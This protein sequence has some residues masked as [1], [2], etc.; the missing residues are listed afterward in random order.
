M[1]ALHTRTHYLLRLASPAALALPLILAG[2]GGGGGGDGAS[3]EQTPSSAGQPVIDLGSYGK[4]I[5]PVQVEGRWYYYW[6]RSG[7]GSTANSGTL[8]GGTDVTTHNTLDGIFTQDA[9]GNAN[10][11]SDTNN[12]YRYA[13]LNGVRVALPTHG[14][15]G[16]RATLRGGTTVSSGAD[17]NYEYDDL[18]AIWDAF[19]G[20]ASAT[21]IN[22][23]PPG[24]P[25]SNY[26]SSTP[27]DSGHASV[28][29]NMGGVYDDL[30]HFAAYVALEV[31]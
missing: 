23:T 6:D 18:L 21:G 25:A 31:L 27:S 4:L 5:A 19:N 26:L 28:H 20:S 9:N 11:G 13:T 16:V 8:N 3:S 22:G 1:K 17:F 29:F 12:T 10:P 15:N 30:D 14:E 7:D 24:W 2:C